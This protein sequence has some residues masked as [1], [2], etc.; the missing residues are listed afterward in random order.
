[1]P[2]G[3]REGRAKAECRVGRFGW[4]NWVGWVVGY[5]GFWFLVGFFFFHFSVKQSH[6]NMGW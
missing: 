5:F 2:V 4:V 6:L 3:P 1:M